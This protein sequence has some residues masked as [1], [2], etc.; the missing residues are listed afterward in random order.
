MLHVWL[1]QMNLL[2]PYVCYRASLALAFLGPQDY[3]EH[4]EVKVSQDQRET[5]VSLAVPVHLD[6]LDSMALREP[7]VLCSLLL[8][9]FK[10]IENIISSH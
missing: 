6:D 8:M 3:Q 7:K 10:E 1:A 2:L 5:L 9:H 4:L